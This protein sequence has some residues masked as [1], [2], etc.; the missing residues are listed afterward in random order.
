MAQLPPLKSLLFFQHAARQMSFKRAAEE[1]NV[2]Q[3]AVSQQVR[4]L[5]EFLGVS[6]FERLNRE[7]RLT[8][9]GKRLLPHIERGFE[10]FHV[11]LSEL[12]LDPDPLKLTVTTVPSFAGHWLVSRLGSFQVEQPELS[13][14]LS[15]SHQLE[16]FK[17]S[18]IDVA[19]R[20]GSGDY[21]EFQSYWLADEYMVPVCHP[22]IWQQIQRNEKTLSDFPLLVDESPELKAVS[23][24]FQQRYGGGLATRGTLH[25]AQA[26]LLVDAVQAGQGVALV[27]YALACDL[28]EKGQLVCFDRVFWRSP[29]QYYLVAPKGHFERK[30]VAL[31]HRWIKDELAL[32]EE[33]WLRLNQQPLQMIT[34]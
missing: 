32:V 3:A 6:L 10:S 34:V 29:Y 25:L 4:Q 21:P 9:E 11:G 2:T 22:L 5:E 14:H 28:I 13:C 8:T 7:V 26:G 1:L 30:K 17:D 31:F 19:V 27:R 12:Q 24:Q 23:A 20:F 18:D 33:K 16:T 15:L